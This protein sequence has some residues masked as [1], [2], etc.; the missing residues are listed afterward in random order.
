M[1]EKELLEIIGRGECHTTEFKK[2]TVDITKDVYESICAFSNRDGGHVFLGVKDNGEILG[3]DPDCIERMKKDFITAINNANKMYPPLFLTP[4]EYVLEGRK[5]LH[6]YVPVGT[7]VSRCAGRIY[8]RN[9]ESDIDITDN[10]ELVYKLYARKQGTY[11]VNKVFPEW[12]IDVLRSELIE[13]A[14]KM[15][16]AR[17]NNH[18][19]LS[20]DDEEMLRSAGLILLDRESRKEGITLAAILLFGKDTTIMSA[21]PQHKTD[22]IFRV[23]NLDRY[24]DRDVIVTNLLDSYDRMSEF[25]KK[26][27]NDPFVLDGMQSV[28]AR[29]A[30]LR[31]IISNSLAHRDY[32]SGY[33]AKMIIEKDQIFTENSNRT[34]GYGNLNLTTF[35]PF[36][37]NPAISKVF[38]EIGLADELGSGMRNTYKFTKL[39]SGGVPQFLE[40]DIFKTIIPLNDTATLKSG[41]MSRDQVSDQVR[42][43]V[44]DQVEQDEVASKIL[45]FCKTARTKKEIS[46]YIGYKNLTYMTRTFLKPL[47]EDGKLLYTIPEKPQ[48]RF[49]RYITKK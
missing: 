24:D 10:E 15:T 12:G 25:A 42:D 8:D 1:S 16:R 33:V 21:L 49:Q 36:P 5:I 47:L 48:S 20:M 13:R 3:I 30:I 2:S 29:D 31:E 18:P 35:E 45:E 34:H 37:K 9:N 44:S 39:Y 11:F 46:E 6:V 14:R 43:Q 28:S 7:Q 4:V 38:R 19:W 23:Q 27:L 32:S 17:S 40:G 26:H 41:P 22:M